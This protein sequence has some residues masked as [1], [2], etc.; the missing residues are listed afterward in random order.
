M[1]SQSG[2]R[3]PARGG[4]PG[5][6]SGPGRSGAARSSSKPAVAAKVAKPE[7]TRTAPTRTPSRSVPIGSTGVKRPSPPRHRPRV[8]GRAAIL[9]LVVAVL[10]ISSASSLR[11]YLVQRSHIESLQ[12]GN[13]E[14]QAA[15]AAQERQI[16]LFDDPAYQETQVRR[17][18][19]WIRPGETPFV[20][21]DGGEPLEADGSLTDPD[22][23]APSTPKAWWTDA[24]GTV[25]EAGNP[26]KRTDP[27]PATRIEDPEGAPSD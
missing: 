27:P 12:Q 16:A 8:T 25:L 2:R 7:P 1:S 15:N 4:R 22:S 11:A 13:A 24:W 3:T 20:V 18:L 6:R 10:A 9:V 14:T 17:N 23:I 21:T 19:G 5:G 26:P